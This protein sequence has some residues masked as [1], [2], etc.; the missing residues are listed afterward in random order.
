V[1]V[2]HKSENGEKWALILTLLQV[3]VC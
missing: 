2:E 3:E 1:T